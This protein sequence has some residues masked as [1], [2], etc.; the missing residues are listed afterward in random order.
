MFYEGN[1]WTARTADRNFGYSQFIESRSF[2]ESSVQ[3]WNSTAL[4][5]SKDA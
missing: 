2:K 3:V 4:T 1:T 5:T